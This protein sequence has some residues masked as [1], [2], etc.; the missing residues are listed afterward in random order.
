[1]VT[2]AGS[3]RRR[4]SGRRSRG[5]RGGGCDDCRHC[6]RHGGVDDDAG[7]RDGILIGTKYSQAEAGGKARFWLRGTGAIR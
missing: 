2:E 7:G 6:D 4:E 5:R 3:G 1:M